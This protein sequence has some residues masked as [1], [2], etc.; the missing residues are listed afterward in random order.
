MVPHAIAG[1]WMAL[2]DVSRYVLPQQ[3]CRM[4]QVVQAA[5]RS[6]NKGILPSLRICREACL[7]SLSIRATSTCP[8]A[9]KPP[10]VRHCWP[11]SGVYTA[12]MVPNTLNTVAARLYIPHVSLHLTGLVTKP[13]ANRLDSQCYQ[14]RLA[15]CLR[16]SQ[17]L[18][19]STYSRGANILTD[20]QTSAH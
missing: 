3:P 10:L 18:C 2:V 7:A 14:S 1:P 6:H 17:Q 9:A 4:M 11:P 19:L 16:Q 5:T 12:R 15:R 8:F 13:P 20:S